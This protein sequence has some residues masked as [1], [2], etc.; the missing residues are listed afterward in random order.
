MPLSKRP[1]TLSDRLR[2]ALLQPSAWHVPMLNPLVRN[3]RCECRW[4]GLIHV[5]RTGV[6]LLAVMF[7]V[8]RALPSSCWSRND[9]EVGQFAAKR[10]FM[11]PDSATSHVVFRL[12]AAASV[13]LGCT[14][15]QA[16]GRAIG[17]ALRSATI[18]C[19]SRGSLRTHRVT[20][21][22]ASLSPLLF[23]AT[24]L[25]WRQGCLGGQRGV[26]NCT[27]L[28][29][30][31][32]QPCDLVQLS[33]MARLRGGTLIDLYPLQQFQNCRMPEADDSMTVAPTTSNERVGA[34]TML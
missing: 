29:S 12:P 9:L 28:H 23:S 20:L 15:A 19:V 33:W 26:A 14:L 7:V 3:A 4:Y 13:H 32:L 22:M 34:Q 2:T 16:Y 24:S 31:A 10:R 18:V 6:G 27:A 5:P 21:E 17:Y 11:G 1:G 8:L 25:C 30:N